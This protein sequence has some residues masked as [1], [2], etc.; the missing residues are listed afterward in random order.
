MVVALASEDG[1]FVLTVKVQ[2]EGQVV[3]CTLVNR[4]GEISP[5]SMIPVRARIALP[6]IARSLWMVMGKTLVC[7]A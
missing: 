1:T 6:L 7:L 5:E 2:G 4:N 3:A